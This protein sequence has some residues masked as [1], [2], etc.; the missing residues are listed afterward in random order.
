MRRPWAS[1]GYTV[2]SQ[3]VIL[4][5]YTCTVHTQIHRC[6]NK[7]TNTQTHKHIKHTHTHTHAQTKTPETHTHIHALIQIK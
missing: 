4:C 3:G 2:T 1:K 5:T 7:H 6:K